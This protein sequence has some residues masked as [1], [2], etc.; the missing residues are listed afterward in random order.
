VLLTLLSLFFL[1]VFAA[2]LHRWLRELEGPGGWL[3]TV[4]LVGGVLMVGMFSVIV[5]LTVAGTVLEGYG[6][7][8][9]IART[10]LV[11][12]WQAL[13]I[14]FMPTAA[15]VGA[16]SL[17]AMHAGAMPRWLTYSG[18]VIAAAL[19]LPPIAYFPFLLSTPWTGMLAIVLLQRMRLERHG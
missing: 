8:P 18:A 12:Q 15:F 11:L 17:V 1:L 19:L 3:A 2:W 14:V 6:D 5:M 10:L 9:V 16:T 13:V 4:S 7:D